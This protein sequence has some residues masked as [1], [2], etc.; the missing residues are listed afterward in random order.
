VINT[1][2]SSINS[3]VLLPVARDLARH[4]PDL[5]LL[6]IGNNEVVGPFGPQTSLTSRASS[7]PLIRTSIFVKS[8]RLGQLVGGMLSRG[9][10][11]GQPTEWRGI[12][13]FLEHQ[14]PADAP[15]ME[16]V[17]HNFRRNLRDIVEAA[18]GSGAPV[19]ISTVGANLKDCG[20]FGSL[21]RPGLTSE[22]K[23]RW[24]ARVRDGQA[25]DGAGRHAAAR[26][27]YLAAAS[28][29][30]RH[31]ELH[32]R[33][34]R[35]YWADGDYERARERFARARDL[36]VLRFRADGR[37]NEI[38]R[39]VAAE[40]GSGVELIDGEAILAAASPNGVPGRELFHE[41]VHLNPRGNYLLAQAFFPRVVARLAD[42]VRSA[43]ATVEPPSQ[44]EAD[45]LLALTPFDRRRVARQVHAWLSQPPFTYQL[46]HAEQV[47]ALERDSAGVRENPEET[48][49]T[50]RWAISRAPKD[51]W[52]RFNHG[53]FLEEQAPAAAVAE[54][55]ASLELLPRDYLAREKLVDVLIK[56][57]DLTAALEE[58]RELL[59][60]MP[61][62]GPA[63]L[64]IA[65][66]LARLGRLDESIEEYERAVGLQPSFAVEVY[67]QIGVI[68]LHQ[69]RFAPAAANFQKAIELDTG[70]VRTAELQY[71][72]RYARLELVKDTATRN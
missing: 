43:A 21:H 35:S 2:I 12:R 72:L 71:N 22:E 65:Y 38:I 32:F 55:R 14:V 6:Y 66:V 62:S 31:A 29:D 60:R 50:Y 30:D 10:R 67:N 13:M 46:D 42:R 25:L 24:E 52:L 54:F 8:T 15:A 20:P 28:I 58:G 4:Q 11:V 34:G 36:D 1:S 53:V 41:H 26:E 44:A 48:A 61:Y 49:N 9:S 3:H 33:I 19:V 69:G 7:I 63:R 51:H 16:P 17:Y 45:R 5:F 39:T 23:E 64:T 59:R 56:T 70:R 68:Q 37:M 40:A 47:S 27:Q 18:A 57:E